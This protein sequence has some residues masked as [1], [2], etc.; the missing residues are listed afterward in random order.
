MRSLPQLCNQ[1]EMQIECTEETAFSMLE[2][3][4]ANRQTDN[5]TPANNPY[6]RDGQNSPRPEFIL[7]MRAKDNE[8][9]LKC[10]A[11]LKK[12]KLAMLRQKN[13]SIGVKMGWLDEFFDIIGSLRRNYIKAER[14]TTRTN[15]AKSLDAC[16]EYT[17]LS[18][19][20]TA[21]APKRTARSQVEQESEKRERGPGIAA[22]HVVK[23]KRNSKRNVIKLQSKLH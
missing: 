6:T 10:R 2:S 7:K 13:V 19:P 11:A 21:A 1:G 4:N 22:W 5:M 9:L 23:G 8:G 14:D 16:T 15:A 20:A 17:D 12:L 18:T 3:T